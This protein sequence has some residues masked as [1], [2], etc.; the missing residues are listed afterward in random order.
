LN[1]SFTICVGFKLGFRLL[2]KAYQQAS[3]TVVCVEHHHI[4]TPQTV[5]RL[6]CKKCNS[7]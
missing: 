6:L 5:Q 7:K 4:V 1:E 3:L 2:G